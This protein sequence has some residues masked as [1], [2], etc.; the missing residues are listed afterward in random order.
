MS[1]PP[2]YTGIL[3]SSRIPLGMASG[4]R[5][6]NGLWPSRDPDRPARG[7]PGPGVARAPSVDDGPLRHDLAQRGRVDGP[8]VRPLGEVQ[9]E[10]GDSPT[11][12][13]DVVKPPGCG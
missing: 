6:E 7:P 1:P 2:D 12:E 9:D 11:S 13:K 4:C 5:G 10:V 8:V 3:A